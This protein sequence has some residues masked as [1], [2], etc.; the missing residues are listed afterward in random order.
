[1]VRISVHTATVKRCC[2]LVNNPHEERG[3]RATLVVHTNIW[4]SLTFYNP[5]FSRPWLWGTACSG[6]L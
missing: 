3:V 2:R 5:V 6:L 1:M 4:G